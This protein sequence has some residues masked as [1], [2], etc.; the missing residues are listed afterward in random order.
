MDHLKDAESWEQFWREV[1]IA[2]I[3]NEVKKKKIYNIDSILARELIPVQNWIRD[4]LIS[5][6]DKL[7]M[8]GLQ[9]SVLVHAPSYIHIY[10]RIA[11]SKAKKYQYDDD[12]IAEIVTY[13]GRAIKLR[14]LGIELAQ[15]GFYVPD[16]AAEMMRKTLTDLNLVNPIHR[17]DMEEVANELE[18]ITFVG[19]G[20][21]KLD[22]II[23]GWSPGMYVMLAGRP[24]HGK[25]A[26]ALNLS[27]NLMKLGKKVVFF[28]LEMDKD[29][30]MRRM[31]ANVAKVDLGLVYRKPKNIPKKDLLDLVKDKFIFFQDLT[32]IND[33]ADQMHSVAVND[34]PDLVVVDY[35]QLIHGGRFD[36][37]NNE[38]ADISRMFMSFKQSTRIPLLILSQ[39]N[40]TQEREQNRRPK[41]SDLRDSG[42]L[43]QDA[44]VVMFIWNEDAPMQSQYR[45]LIVAKGR[46]TGIGDVKFRF[47]GKTQSFAQI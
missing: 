4:A 30:I 45:T 1:Q 36:S 18:E 23:G 44:D 38:L 13:F 34:E 7:D 28:S 9:V 20:F 22:N 47:N 26:M 39:L 29:Q 46:N 43:E 5:D 25:T 24:G 6:S 31:L 35:I 2:L 17:V 33:I 10:N 8:S 27:I 32:N 37:R 41:L 12:Q 21:N 11:S 16:R 42:A 14:R 19:T 3:I 40:R 15:L